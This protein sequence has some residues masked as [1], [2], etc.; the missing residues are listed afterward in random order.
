M[1]RSLL[2]AILV[3]VCAG[4]PG[5]A[6]A[7]TGDVWD[8]VEHGYADHDGVRIHYV[9][10]GEG[11]LVVMIHGF[12]DFWYLWRHH[13]E[14]LSETYQVAAIDQRGYNRSDKPTGAERYSFEYLVGDV[15]AVI[16]HLGH[17]SAT[18]VGHDWGGWVT[19]MFGMERPEMADGLIIFNLPHPRG[20]QRE[21]ALNR[22]QKENS[23]YARRFQTEG[24]HLRM[25]AE[26]LARRHEGDATVHARYVE[27]Y[28]RSDFEA[29]LNYYKANYPRPPYLEDTSE[30][31][32]VRPPVL[33]FHGLGDTALLHDMLNGTWEWLE[34]DLTLV[35]IPDAGH[36]AVTEKADF[37]AQMMKAWLA[38]QASQGGRR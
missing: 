35:T 29:M 25:T 7:Q 34:R 11:P 3:A 26:Q 16:E 23:A 20:A 27:A 37:T 6:A 31:I 9:T 2:L 17:Q 22:E 12:P 19:W 18:V 21:L 28:R 5:T 24:A 1:H 10:L 38:L 36:W 13:L 32:K 14:A 33:Q 30:V 4:A 8:R 15:A